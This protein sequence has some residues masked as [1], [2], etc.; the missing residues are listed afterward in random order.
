MMMT[1]TLFERIIRH[2]THTFFNWSTIEDC[3]G[4]HRPT[5]DPS[6][7]NRTDSQSK[8]AS[9]NLPKTGCQLWA[10]A[11]TR[12]IF[13][14][15]RLHLNHNKMMTWGHSFC[16]TQFYFCTNQHLS[17]LFGFINIVYD[18]EFPWLLVEA[19][20]NSSPDIS[21][22]LSIRWLCACKQTTDQTGSIWQVEEQSEKLQR[23]K[24]T[25]TLTLDHNSHTENP[26]PP[27]LFPAVPS[28]PTKPRPHFTSPFRPPGPTLWRSLWPLSTLGKSLW[29]R[30][31][32]RPWPSPLPVRWRVSSRCPASLLRWPRPAR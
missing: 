12:L 8:C 13:L 22:S 14:L 20:T 27:T 7:A 2:F 16:Y 17:L 31:L 28:P 19:T 5:V 9:P 24:E 30:W 25:P 26:V 3:R 11:C 4:C 15:Q 21:S 10:R 32:W 18:F 1:R 6:P 29:G 23:G